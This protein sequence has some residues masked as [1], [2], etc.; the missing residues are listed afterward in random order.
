MRIVRGASGN[1]PVATRPV[2]KWFSAAH[3]AT[4]AAIEAGLTADPREPIL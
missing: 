1:D 2:A 3:R 4:E